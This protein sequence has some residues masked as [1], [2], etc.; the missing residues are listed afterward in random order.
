MD[1]R[2]FLKVGTQTAALGSA[3]ITIPSCKPEVIKVNSNSNKIEDVSF[4][5]LKEYT[6]EDHRRRLENIGFCTQ[7]VQGYMRRHLVTNYLPGHATYNLG[8]YPAVSPWNPDE[9]DEQDLDRLKEHG[10][11]VLQVFDEWNDSLRLFG[12]DKF[13]AVN[14]EGYRRFLAMAHQRGMKVLT[15]TSATFLER[16]HPEFR[17]EWMRE[18][19]DLVGFYWDMAC[20]SPGSPGWRAFLFPRLRRILDEYGMDGLYMDSGY[21]V[22]SMYANKKRPRLSMKLRNMTVHLQIFLH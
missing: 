12:G 19:L 2:K 3:I 11:Q 18:G 9:R 16:A 22:N 5:L 7:A 17:R 14:P 1:R 8:E 15:Y 13:E 4:S 10:I 20:N 6:E 21:F